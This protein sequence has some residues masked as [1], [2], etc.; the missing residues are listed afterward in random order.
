MKSTNLFRA[1]LVVMSGYLVSKLVGIVREPLIAR[2]FGTG[3]SLDA[4]YAAFNIPD[5][6]FTLIAGGALATAFIPLF[7][8]A[9]SQRGRDE[10]WRMAS[11]VINL[12]LL[13]T[14]VLALVV[15]LFAPQI[16]ACCLAPGFSAAQQNL[17]VD[18]M[19]LILISTIVFALAGVLMG[20]L[21]AQQHFASP[22][23]A[24]A[25]Y[26]LGIIGGTIFLAPRFGVYGLAY[27]VIIGSLLHLSSHFP[28][29]L[30]QGIRYQ[31]TL[32]LRDPLI[33]QLGQLMGPRILAL[34]VIKINT[35]VATN[36]ASRLEAGS[37]SA[38]NFAWLVMQIPETIIATAIA[39]A[40]FPTLSQYAV[41][42]QHDQLRA[43]MARALR[44]ILLLSVP[45][46]L[47]LLLLGRPVVQLLFQGGRFNV[48]S[49]NAVVWALNFYALGLLGHSFLEIGSRVFYAQKDTLTPLIAATFAMFINAILAIMLMNVLGHGG[50]ALA[51]SIAVSFE[52]SLLLWIAQRRLQGIEWQ[53]MFGLTF[54]AGLA[55]SLMAT[56][57]LIIEGMDVSPLIALSSG[58]LAAAIYFAAMWLMGVEEV[59]GLLRR[60]V[61]A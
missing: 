50:I 1:T 59:R 6:L 15:A 56:I 38:L 41:T 9:L 3:E 2:A 35:L 45:A 47:G 37:V 17:T 16:V 42:G 32:M 20:I 40:L 39:T 29:L 44:S 52:V 43:A 48:E 33:W 24:P 21:N 55:A 19:R 12:V 36:L 30:R 23:F 5:L 51:N 25:L 8:E 4:Y 54:R 49:T 18:L 22:A 31:P 14:V 34:G 7:T 46:L 57:I 58:A 60:R 61:P 10:A 53:R 11:A 26:N 27:G 28:P 13:S